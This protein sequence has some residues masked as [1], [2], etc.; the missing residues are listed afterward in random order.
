M[1]LGLQIGLLCAVAASVAGMT[2]RARLRKSAT[3]EKREQRRRLAVHTTGRLGDG[4]ITD[5]N[6][7][8]LFY[9]YSVRG[10]QYAAAQDVSSLRDRLPA[11]PERLIGTTGIKY[12]AQN[13]ANSIVICEEWSGLR[14]SPRGLADDVSVGTVSVHVSVDNDAVGHQSQDAALT[15][16]ADR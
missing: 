1:R 14:V 12:S 16:S 15:E 5:A 4:I 9:T 10:V 6:E 2:L 11:D 7:D 13:P 8:A 3:P